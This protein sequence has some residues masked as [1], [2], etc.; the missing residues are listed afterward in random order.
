[1]HIL[2][3]TN[4]DV[5]P[6]EPMAMALLLKIDSYQK[7]MHSIKLNNIKALTYRSLEDFQETTLKIIPRVFSE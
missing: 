1:M 7:Q 5:P 2:H 4:L 6:L 3:Y